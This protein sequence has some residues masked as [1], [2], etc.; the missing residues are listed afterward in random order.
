MI[1]SRVNN[2]GIRYEH[3]SADQGKTWT[4]YADSALVDPGCNGSIIRYSSVKE[5][6][7][8]DRILIS[9]AANAKERNNLTIR[10]SYDNGKTW[11]YSK[12]I[13]PNGAAYSSMSI[14]KDGN[15]AVFYEKDGHH[16]NEVA[17]FSL[18]WLTDGKDNFKKVKK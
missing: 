14:M 18:G 13:H 9:H 1:N 6:D 7:D 3:I 17:T 10:L 12:T 16:L 5:G 8:K 15:I 4:S 11:A 2:S